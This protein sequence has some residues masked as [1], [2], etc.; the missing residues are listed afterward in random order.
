MKNRNGWKSK[1][2]WRGKNWNIWNRKWNV[3]NMSR[4][5]NW[6]SRRNRK[7]IGFSLYKRWNRNKRKKLEKKLRNSDNGRGINIKKMKRLVSL[8]KDGKFWNYREGKC[9]MRKGVRC[10]RRFVCWS[11]VYDNSFWWSRK[12]LLWNCYKMIWWRMR[13]ESERKWR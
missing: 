2:R 11:W 10:L 9:L 5:V 1:K 12:R 8:W 13:L 4:S 7:K 3:W 6:K